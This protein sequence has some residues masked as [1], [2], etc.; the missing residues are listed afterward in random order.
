MKLACGSGIA[1]LK[2]GTETGLLR[3]QGSGHGVIFRVGSGVVFD[4]VAQDEVGSGVTGFRG[5][6][7]LAQLCDGG[8]GPLCW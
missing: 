8:G 6:Q 1:S 7:V 4:L 5:G 3:A 2:R